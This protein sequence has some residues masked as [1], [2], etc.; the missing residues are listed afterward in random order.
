MFSIIYSIFGTNAAGI[1]GRGDAGLR[2]NGL[3]YSRVYIGLG[4]GGY[5]D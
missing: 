2:V 5:F 1:A 3:Y 4:R